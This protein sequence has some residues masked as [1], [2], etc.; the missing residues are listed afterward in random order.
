MVVSVGR[1]ARSLRPTSSVLSVVVPVYNVAEYLPDCLNSVLTQDLPRRTSLEVVCV[2][3]GSTDD[4]AAILERL[5]RDDDRVVVVR[6]RNSGL[7]A[8]R[9]AGVRRAT[10]DLLTFV[11][12]DDLVPAGAYAAM[13]ASL[14][15]S[16]SD[17]VVGALERFDG[18]QISMGPLMRENHLTSRRAVS[19][20]EEPLLLADVFAV[21]KVYRRDFWDAVGA[22]F[23][24]DTRY[25]DQPTLTRVLLGA[26]TVDVL[27]ESVYR[28]RIRADGSSITQ[29][30]G[31]IEDLRDRIAT[32][33]DSTE[34]VQ[35]AGEERLLPVW[36]RRILPV[37][38]WEYFRAAPTA[39]DE[40]WRLLVDGVRQLWPPAVSG[41]ELTSVPVQQRLMGALVSRDRKVDLVAVLEAIDRRG[42]QPVS[43]GSL[44]VDLPCAQDPDLPAEAW[45]FSQREAAARGL[46]READ[47]A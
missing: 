13:I 22:S 16:D 6:Q 46:T 25:E 12:S 20:V 35:A 36:F 32:K 23:P 27:S 47:Q 14:H 8:A 24:V 44:V 41:F 2:D 15:S 3:D 37:D 26:G 43:D 21:N 5:M 45:T 28:W 18:D 1:L 40:Y 29:G 4:S 42:V 30:R 39:G 38:M 7:G 33:L 10:G 19:V 31:R 9:N 17:L 11:D 34:R